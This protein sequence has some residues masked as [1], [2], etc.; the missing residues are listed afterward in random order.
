MCLTSLLGASDV[1]QSL[2]S[3]VVNGFLFHLTSLVYKGNELSGLCFPVVGYIIPYASALI[4]VYKNSKNNNDVS[5]H[6]LNASSI[7]VWKMLHA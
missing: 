3:T 7:T 1:Q 5:L 6:L 2:R 4:N